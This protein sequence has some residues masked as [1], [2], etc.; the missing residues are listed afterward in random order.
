MSAQLKAALYLAEKLLD[1]TP[2]VSVQKYTI[3]DDTLYEV[4]GES[5][6]S[7][8]FHATC[9]EKNTRYAGIMGNRLKHGIEHRIAQALGGTALRS[10]VSW[11]V[12]Y[13]GINDG[14]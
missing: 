10:D 6:E 2:I 11:M 8:V 7:V 4:M 14:R 13:E 3:G 9:S 1:V 5:D 12:S